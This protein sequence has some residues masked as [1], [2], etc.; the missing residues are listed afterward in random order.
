ML[1]EEVIKLVNDSLLYG[2]KNDDYAIV[3][4][5]YFYNNEKIIEKYGKEFDV[6][7][8]QVGTNYREFFYFFYLG[9]GEGEVSIDIDTDRYILLIR[10]PWFG[11][12][13]VEEFIE[14]DIDDDSYFNDESE[15][16]YIEL[17]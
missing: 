9:N 12:W 4:L 10:K 7:N 17:K 8:D 1:C 13:Y 14:T 6:K 2:W 5:D 11:K 16:G 3:A 15:D